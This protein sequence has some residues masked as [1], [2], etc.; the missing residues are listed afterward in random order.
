MG[1][2]GEDKMNFYTA[3]AEP[4]PV[5]GKGGGAEHIYQS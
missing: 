2:F 1:I 5:K 4:G 3:F